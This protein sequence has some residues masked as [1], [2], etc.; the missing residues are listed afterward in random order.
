MTARAALTYDASVERKRRA[1]VTKREPE[2]DARTRLITA[3]GRGGMTLVLGAGVSIEAGVPNWQGLAVRIWRRAFK[4]L[5]DGSP[6]DQVDVEKAVEN[7]QLFPI[8]FELAQ[9]RL[10]DQE[11]IDALRDCIYETVQHRMTR[12]VGTTVGTI[13]AIL[14]R[15]HGLGPRRRIVRVVT[16][17]ADELLREA[18]RGL[19]GTDGQ[20]YQTMDHAFSPIP[21]GRGEQHVPIYHVH[22][23]LPRRGAFAASYSE[24]RLVFTDSE[25]WA[26]GTAQASFA[27][28]TMNAA[29]A[30]SHCVFIGLSMTDA[31][32]LRWLALRH[33]EV[34]R[35]A[36]Y[37]KD[38]AAEPA[39]EGVAQK[40][41]ARHFW[42]RA[43]GDDRTGLLSAFL[44]LRGVD[45]V[46]I[47][48]WKDGSFAKLIGECFPDDDSTEPKRRRTPRAAP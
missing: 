13:A 10:G 12:H 33:N 42:V 41:L 20:F 8:I 6:V 43:P 17:N 19:T 46:E 21:F 1:A 48:D 37:R 4:T 36:S 3:A 24:H 26:S 40:D 32:L 9:Q 45:S 35:D 28:R 22:G 44:R 18:L 30:D 34:K 7:P 11:F 39:L 16:F 23:F 15:D 38:R 29:L 14:K 25:Y 5:G 2:T 47:S 31:N 27:N